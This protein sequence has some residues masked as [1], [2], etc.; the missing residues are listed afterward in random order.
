MTSLTPISPLEP[1]KPPSPVLTPAQATKKARAAAHAPARAIAPCPLP[2]KFDQKQLDCYSVHQ[3]VFW[4]ETHKKCD[5]QI[6][7]AGRAGQNKFVYCVRTD[8]KGKIGNQKGTFKSTNPTKTNVKFNKETRLALGV[9]L[10]MKNDRTEEGQRCL[11]F[12]YTE[13]I[14]IPEAD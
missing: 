9:V 8:A 11:P 7:T 5:L 6:K 3:V 2:P 13:Q 14:I 4:E 1:P 10:V 12:D